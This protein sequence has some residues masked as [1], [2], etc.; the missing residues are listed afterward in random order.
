MANKREIKKDINYLTNEILIDGIMLMS[1]YGEK[2]NAAIIKELEKVLEKRNSFISSIQNRDGK[3]QRVSKEERK[4]KRKERTK[5]FKQEINKKF[6]EFEVAL[7][8]AYDAFG[9]LAKNKE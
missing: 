6:N 7:D 4:N 1:I 2:E 5:A 9:N 8:A 3:F